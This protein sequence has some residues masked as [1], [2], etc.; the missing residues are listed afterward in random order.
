MKYAV[1][2]QRGGINR[3]TNK[4]PK[5][6]PEGAT[7]QEISDEQADLIETGRNA[8]PRIFYGFRAG[9][10]IPMQE[11]FRIH[12]AE[13][14]TMEQ[15][16]QEGEQFVSRFFNAD[17]KVTL[18]DMLLQFKEAGNLESKPKLVAVYQ[19]MQTVKGMAIAG[20]LDFPEPPFSFDQILTE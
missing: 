6:L 8:T 19:W 11:L 18:L 9:N 3:V 14:M 16:I 12:R 15:K 1:I 20:Q 17:R 4:E 7:V 2:N 5:A 10:L 13:E